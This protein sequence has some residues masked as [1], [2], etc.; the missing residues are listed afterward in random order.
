MKLRASAVVLFI[1]TVATPVADAQRLARTSVFAGGDVENYLRYLQTL[2]LVPLYPWG[3]RAFSPTEVDHLL[4]ADTSH[5][6]TAAYDFTSGPRGFSFGW[7]SPAASARF[8][9]AFPYG[10]NDGPIWAGRGLTLVADGGFQARRGGLSL[11]IA[12]LAFV[13]QNTAFPLMPNGATGN[14]VYGDGVQWAHIDRPQ[15]FGGSSYARLDPGQSTLRL[16]WRALAG[17]ITTANQYWGPASEFPIILGNNAPGFPH[18]FLGTAHPVDLW[19]VRLHGRLVWGRT[20]Q[21]AFSHEPAATGLRYSSAI[22]LDVTSRWVPGLELGATRFSHQPWPPGGPTFNDLLD[23]FRVGQGN[24]TNL[25]AVNQLASAFFRWVAPRSGFEVYGEYGR[26]D[27]NQN[28]RDFLLE[29][30]HIGGYT[31]GF[32]KIT[33]RGAKLLAVRVETQNLQFSHLAR[34]R[35]WAPFYTHVAL[36]QGHTQDGQ[37]LGSEAGV[38]GAGSV[39][40]IESYSPH[41]RWTWSWTRLIRQQRG[42]P[43]G[44][45][46]VDPHGVDVQHAVAVERLH[47]GRR[48]DSV[49]R[50][51]A[52]YELNRDFASD[53]FSLNLI[54]GLRLGAR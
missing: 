12:P 49:A 40:A 31:I 3:A 28:F 39:V 43:A 8:N 48:Y 10:F 29:P 2:G 53:A 4:P 34:G 44:A 51:T 24:K 38:G 7:V 19:L 32:R 41:G 54:L 14:Q 26:D 37:V 13:A 9:T 30:D 35:G 18:V 27:Y 21:S 5:P 23:M 16:E 15:R 46:Q 42:D 11:T 52:V 36:P 47:F 17:G 6:W 22:V 45:T 33:R 1:L 25:A 20:S 50:L